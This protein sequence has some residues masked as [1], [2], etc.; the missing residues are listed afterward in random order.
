MSMRVEGERREIE[1]TVR[2]EQGKDLGICMEM[3]GW[4]VVEVMGS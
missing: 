3:K 4:E 1:E 2:R